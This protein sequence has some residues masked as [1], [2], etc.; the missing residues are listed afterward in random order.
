MVDAP[1]NSGTQQGPREL[2][3]DLPAEPLRLVVLVGAADTRAS[4]AD[5]LEA[6]ARL[7]EGTVAYADIG[8]ALVAVVDDGGDAPEWFTTLPQRV[9][10]CTSGFQTG[11][12]CG[13]GDRSGGQPRPPRW[14]ARSVRRSPGWPKWPARAC[15]V[16]PSRSARIRRFAAEQPGAARRQ[17]TATWSRRC[18][19]GSNITA[20]GIPWR[21]VSASTGTR[22]DTACAR[23]RSCLAVALTRPTSGP[24]CGWRRDCGVSWT[25]TARRSASDPARRPAKVCRPGFTCR[26][27]SSR[28]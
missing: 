12:L 21:P 22:C 14:G 23:W 16:W 7:R 17:R 18:G 28:V 25:T 2:W 20:S 26:C 19:Y 9:A 10:G 4:A 1:T 15:C 13:P 27:S 24:S 11:R 3:G 6:E 5:L 8:D